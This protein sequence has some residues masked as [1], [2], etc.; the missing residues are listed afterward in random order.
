MCPGRFEKKHSCGPRSEFLI[1]FQEITTFFIISLE[2]DI[3]VK[4]TALNV[5]YRSKKKCQWNAL[6][7]LSLEESE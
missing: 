5:A 1:Y 3:P 2:R 4:I 7:F 6:I